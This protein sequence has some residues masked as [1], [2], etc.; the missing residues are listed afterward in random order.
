MIIGAPEAGYRHFLY[1]MNFNFCSAY[2]RAFKVDIG[3]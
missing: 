2:L 3:V 1:V